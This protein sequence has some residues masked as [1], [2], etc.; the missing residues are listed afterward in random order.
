[1]RQAPLLLALSL[2]ALSTP[3]VPADDK[4]L[5]KPERALRTERLLLLKAIDQSSELGLTPKDVAEL[6]PR[7]VRTDPAT[8]ERRV[9]YRRLT[10]LML[11]EIDR[12]AKRV[13]EL[14]RVR[15]RAFPESE[16]L[17]RITVRRQDS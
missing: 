1:M 3:A 13:E 14:E 15:S 10:S 12:L 4:P 5:P 6:F 7:L 16:P 9:R 8:G 17:V 11:V 2:L